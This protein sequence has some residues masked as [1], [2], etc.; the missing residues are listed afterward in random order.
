MFTF[1]KKAEALAE[2]FEKNSSDENYSPDF[3]N[4]KSKNET[5]NQ[6]TISQDENL[7]PI[8]LPINIQELFDAHYKCNS[9]NSTGHDEIPY[10]FIE[11]LPFRRNINT[12]KTIMQNAINEISKWEK[13]TG[14]KFGPAKSKSILFTYKRNKTP[15]QIYMNNIQIPPHMT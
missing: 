11:Q 2:I 13:F 3:R 14:F 9:K 8:N 7:H 6:I 12:S 4:S 5:E 10:I 15:P 1:V